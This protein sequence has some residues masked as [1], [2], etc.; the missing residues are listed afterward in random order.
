MDPSLL[1]PFGLVAVNFR[2]FKMFTDKWINKQR[3]KINSLYFFYVFCANH[4]SCI[5]LLLMCLTLS[6]GLFN[7]MQSLYWKRV[8]TLNQFK[9]ENDEIR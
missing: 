3:Y 8:P 2:V 4:N 7:M 1:Y 5:Y 9:W 6:L